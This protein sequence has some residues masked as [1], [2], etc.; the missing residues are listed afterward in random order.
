MLQD[1]PHTARSVAILGDSVNATGFT[2]T[3]HQ[4]CFLGVVT[5][6]LILLW[7]GRGQRSHESRANLGYRVILPLKKKW[8]SGERGK[9]QQ[10]PT[11]APSS[12]STGQHPCTCV[13]SECPKATWEGKDLFSLL[14]A[15]G[16]L[17]LV[18]S[19]Q[20]FE[21]ELKERPWRI[22]LL[23][24]QLAFFFFFVT[25]DHLPRVAPPK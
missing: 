20:E 11:S 10:V 24:V 19:R 2:N 18:R 17:D 1:Q 9:T 16:H 3:A 23:S 25:Q 5:Q 12:G 6:P 8:R 7:G 4:K 14:Q 15:T 13:S 22:T 21:K